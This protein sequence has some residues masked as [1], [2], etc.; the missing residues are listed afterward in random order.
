MDYPGG[1]HEVLLRFKTNLAGLMVK[2]T[3]STEATSGVEEDVA[4]LVHC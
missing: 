3:T 1:C 2:L 4:S